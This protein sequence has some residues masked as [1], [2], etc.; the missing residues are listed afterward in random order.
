ME[1]CSGGEGEVCCF[2]YL[3]ACGS[4][5]MSLSFTLRISRLKRKEGTAMGCYAEPGL[6]CLEILVHK[7]ARKHLIDENSPTTMAIRLHFGRL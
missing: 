3:A 6:N 7:L 4:E 1:I 5:M 2:S